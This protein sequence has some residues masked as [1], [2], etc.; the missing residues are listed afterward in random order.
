M[1]CVFVAGAYSLSF[2]S[3][4]GVMDV[5]S[6]STGS[7]LLDDVTVS[8]SD[9]KGLYGLLLYLSSLI[10]LVP[11]IPLSSTFIA[12]E[13]GLVGFVLLETVWISISSSS[14]DKRFIKL[15]SLSIAVMVFVVF[16]ELIT[17]CA[18]LLVVGGCF[19]FD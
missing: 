3:K 7:S 12:A 5:F 6:S 16:V 8:F 14:S 13:F 11:T 17:L 4:V 10:F 19:W 2:F 15:F 18:A 9:T 1:N